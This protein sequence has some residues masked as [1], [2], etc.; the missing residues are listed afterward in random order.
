MVFLSF[1]VAFVSFFGIVFFY[2]FFCLFLA[3]SLAFLYMY[4]NIMADIQFGKNLKPD[5]LLAAT[6]FF[7]FLLFY[8][9]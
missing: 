2:L 7:L 1:S 9:E 4:A 8:P 3:S 6:I 5:G